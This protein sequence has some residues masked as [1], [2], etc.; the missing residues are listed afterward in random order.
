[1]L[2]SLKEI[3]FEQ[4]YQA[5]Q[6]GW[7]LYL[8]GSTD[9]A[10]LRAFAALL[11]H[12]AAEVLERPFVHY[13]QN[14]PN[15]AREHFRGLREA[16]PDLLGVALFDRLNL[17]LEATPELREV[18]W[19]RREIENY[20]C[21]PEVLHAYAESTAIEESGGPLFSKAHVA[22]R[23]KVMAAAI[24]EVESAMATLGLGSPWSPD[25]KVSDHFLQRVFEKYFKNLNLPNLMNKTDFHE[26]AKLVPSQLID[27][28]VS[29]K[30]D[31]IL[32]IASIARPR[33]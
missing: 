8:E 30:L 29:Q 18:M 3:G 5:E 1:V 32:R 14:Q 26:L 16:K 28:E 22:Q 15:R 11:E 19:Q 27:Q 4:Y 10:I 9:L 21:Y 6:V 31:D 24:A 25:T 17:K 33:Q 12:P 20:L 23:K 2:K 13:V 7:V